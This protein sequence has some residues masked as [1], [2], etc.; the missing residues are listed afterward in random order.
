MNPVFTPPALFLAR[1][2]ELEQIQIASVPR[3][4][5]FFIR[6]LG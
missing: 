1:A 2:A 4:H 5:L 6:L 3:Q